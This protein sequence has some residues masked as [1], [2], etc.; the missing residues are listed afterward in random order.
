MK[1]IQVKSIFTLVSSTNKTDSHGI[2]EI[3]LKVA[4]YTI[5]LKYPMSLSN[6]KVTYNTKSN[7]HTIGI[8]GKKK[9]SEMIT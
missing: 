3:L 8:K 6:V 4:L 9:E 7:Y 2:T 5:K 1:N